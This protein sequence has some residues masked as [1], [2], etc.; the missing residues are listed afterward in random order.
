MPPGITRERLEESRKDMSNNGRMREQRQAVVN[1]A[2]GMQTH[3]PL[4]GSKK[5]RVFSGHLITASYCNN[6][7]SYSAMTTVGS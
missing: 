2:G 5:W 6:S 7:Y 1:F 3:H 4:Y